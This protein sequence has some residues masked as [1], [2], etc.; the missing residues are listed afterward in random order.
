[1]RK[2]VLGVVG[3]PLAVF[4]KAQA[5][6]GAGP[7]TVAI[8]QNRVDVVIGQAIRGGEFSKRKCGME[9]GCGFTLAVAALWTLGVTVPL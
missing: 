8:Y 2:A 7:D 5:I 1:M 4:V 6:I 3:L 9:G